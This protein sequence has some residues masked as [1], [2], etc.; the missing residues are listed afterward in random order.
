[1][2][3]RGRRPAASLSPGLE[4]VRRPDGVLTLRTDLE[5]LDGDRFLIEVTETAPGR[6]PL[7]DRGHT[8]MHISYDHDVDAL[9]RLEGLAALDRIL[10][11]MRVKREGA[12]F[13]VDT[14]VADIGAAGIR[15]GQALSRISELAS[16][17][18]G[19]TPP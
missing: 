7:F 12:V 16:S 8:V 5:F 13:S 3:N 15:F 4:F 2:R 11:D 9:F 19:R 18:A 10:T 14:A 17:T 1:M 6:V